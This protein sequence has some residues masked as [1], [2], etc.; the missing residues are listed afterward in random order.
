MW[1]IG[2]EDNQGFG[3]AVDFSMSICIIIALFHGSIRKVHRTIHT[4]CRPRTLVRAA[5]GL[6]SFIDAQIY[7]LLILHSKLRKLR[8]IKAKRNKYAFVER[9]KKNIA[10][11]VLYHWK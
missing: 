5:D 6:G 2:L 10:M 4:H 8:V 3:I 1:R 11:T 7:L 9:T